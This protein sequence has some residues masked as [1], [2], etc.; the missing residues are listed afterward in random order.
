MA[1]P[2]QLDEIAIAARIDAIAS[3]PS[4]MFALFEQAESMPQ[5]VRAY[6]ERAG[7][8]RYWRTS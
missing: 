4:Q 3:Y 7:G 6:I 8:E 1:L 2:I 5:R